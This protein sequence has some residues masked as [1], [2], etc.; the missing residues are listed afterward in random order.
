MIFHKDHGNSIIRQGW[1]RTKLP[2]NVNGM[3]L[4]GIGKC[5]RAV[6]NGHLHYKLEMKDTIEC[7]I[8]RYLVLNG[9]CY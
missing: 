6:D 3:R 7:A 5:S 8:E 1:A 9:E 2:E 4:D